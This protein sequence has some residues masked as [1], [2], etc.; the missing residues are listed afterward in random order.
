MYLAHHEK[1]CEQF[2]FTTSTLHTTACVERQLH[3]SCISA[4]VS[5]FLHCLQQHAF[6]HNK[7][8]QQP[9]MLL[10]HKLLWEKL[11]QKG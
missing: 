6:G 10:G 8:H 9:S 7:A 3:G 11:L 4:H 1:E 2:F 5:S